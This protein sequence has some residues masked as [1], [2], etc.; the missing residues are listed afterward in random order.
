MTA[1]QKPSVLSTAI[2]SWE[3]LILKRKCGA[4][5]R[6]HAEMA[7]P[8]ATLAERCVPCSCRLILASSANIAMRLEVPCGAALTS[9]PIAI[10]GIS[11][12][13]FCAITDTYPYASSVMPHWCKSES[14]SRRQL[15]ARFGCLH[16]FNR[17]Q[18]TANNL[19]RRL[20]NAIVKKHYHIHMTSNSLTSTIT[21]R[22]R[23]R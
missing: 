19:S 20:M 12:N 14:F 6:R 13:V 10:I 22:V 18:S 1:I 16:L 9:S 8:L 2:F 11:T 7:M 21:A 5:D 3:N 15:G 4:T 23:F 17:V